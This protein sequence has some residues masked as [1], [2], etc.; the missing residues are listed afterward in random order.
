M[1]LM[2]LGIVFGSNLQSV[3]ARSSEVFKPPTRSASVA[4]METAV[5]YSLFRIPT[6]LV[7][8]SLEVQYLD[9]FL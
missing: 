8:Y 6:I 4:G 2:N 9:R 5:A 3:F 1:L 7:P